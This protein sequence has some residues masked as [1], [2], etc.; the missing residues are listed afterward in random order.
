MSKLNLKETYGRLA[1]LLGMNPASR[2]EAPSKL[3]LKGTYS[4]LVHLLSKNPAFPEP[5]QTAVGGEFEAIGIVEREMLRFYGLEPHHVLVDVGCGSGRLAIPL[6]RD[7]PGGYLG[8][9]LVE[10]L[11]D[12]ARAR[13]NRPDWRFAVV[14]H[15]EIPAADESADMICFFSVLTHVLHE[16]SY[17]YLEEARRVLKPG[18][19]IVF[20]FL[21]FAN[22]NHWRIFDMTLDDTRGP[23]VHPLNVFIDRAAI[24]CW[25]QK[26]NLPVVEI[27]D[28]T[29]AFVPLR[30]PVQFE[31]GPKFSGL[32]S[33]HQAVC[34]LEK[35]AA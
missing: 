22:P 28:G 15:L 25:S 9:D 34:V 10:E 29:D 13:C 21:E 20:S 27:R 17:L 6:S 23:N 16:H 4:R 7:H 30:E 19:R 35:P 31:G 5:L 3:D 11:I 33:L 18:G 1:R 32:G 24:R 8:T 14:D 12:Y 26:L 2:E